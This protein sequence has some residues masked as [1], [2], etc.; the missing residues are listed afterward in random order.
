[1]A[2]EWWKDFFGGLVVEFWKAAMTP[3]VTRAEADFLSRTLRLAPGARVLDIACGAGRLTIELAARGCRM[4]GVDI[5]SEF[6]GAGRSA[7][8]ESGLEIEWREADMRDLPWESAFD[9][10]FCAGSSFGFLGDEG[11]AAFLKAVSR[12]LRPGGRFFADFK[13]AESILPNFRESREMTL[14]DLRFES[15]NRYD[16]ASGTMESVYTITR[17][18]DSETK[19]AVHR[20]YT[21]R[22][23]LRM[24]SDAGFGEL[25]TY[26]SLEGETFR[27][28]S[29]NL[30]V[31]VAKT[32]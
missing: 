25:E 20:I 3:G 1:M 6:L 28:G 30:L 24:L 21:T 11:D 9:A 26:G 31:V 15:K 7:V 14:G 29:P 8:R 18:G 16:P 10:A 17:D 13:A 19:R 32:R 23:I 12:T 22:E 2:D 4:T 27:L 5:S